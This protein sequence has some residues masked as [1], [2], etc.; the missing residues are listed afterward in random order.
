MA[1]SRGEE[2]PA[3]S[4][5]ACLRFD[6]GTQLKPVGFLYQIRGRDER[7]K[8]RS[9]VVQQQSTEDRSLALSP[10]YSL[11]WQ[12]SHNSVLFCNG[13]ILCQNLKKKN[14]LRNHRQKYPQM[15]V[16][17]ASFASTR[18][19][20]SRRTGPQLRASL[21]PTTAHLRSTSLLV[22]FNVECLT[23]MESTALPADEHGMDNSKWL[24]DRGQLSPWS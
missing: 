9:N 21:L 18:E 16:L 5:V 10:K 13:I 1:N 24:V 17:I 4:C 6:P 11:R 20:I 8:I 15:L 7:V 23:W 3:V 2:L 12:S 22:I 14:I 19:H